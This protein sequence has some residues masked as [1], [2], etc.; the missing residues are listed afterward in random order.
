[1]VKT[2]SSGSH[3]EGAMKVSPVEDRFTSAETEKEA[4]VNLFTVFHLA[5]PC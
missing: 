5:S 1:M 4:R 3:T 2:I